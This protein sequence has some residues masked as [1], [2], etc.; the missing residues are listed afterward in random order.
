MSTHKSCVDCRFHYQPFA[1][2]DEE[3]MPPAICFAK[4][5]MSKPECDKY[6]KQESEEDK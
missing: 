5:D 6:E 4:P 3:G 2:T 1:R